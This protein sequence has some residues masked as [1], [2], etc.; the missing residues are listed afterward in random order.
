[1]ISRSAVVFP[2]CLPICSSRTDAIENPIVAAALPRS[3]FQ[4]NP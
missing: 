4:T 2:N 3:D 1:L